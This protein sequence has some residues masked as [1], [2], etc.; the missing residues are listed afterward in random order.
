MTKIRWKLWL[1]VVQVVLAI[2]LS[3]VGKV[4]TEHRLRGN[5]QVWDYI[6]PAEI[7]LHAINYP[8]AVATG[9]T[10]RDRTFQI[11]IEYSVGAFLVYLAY[12]L[13]LWYVVGWCIGK[14]WTASPAGSRVPIWLTLL[15]I[16]G[17]GLLLL[18]AFT[19]L[20]GAY[21]LLLVVSAFLWSGLFLLAFSTMLALRVRTHA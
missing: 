15:G 21:G 13:V 14:C 4:Q 8:A 19:M 20:R 3:L 18:V 5:V 10:V 11:G 16:L 6:A 7:V 1:P 2:A 9:L 17:G 12:I